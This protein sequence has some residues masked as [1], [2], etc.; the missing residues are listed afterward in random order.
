[1]NLLAKANFK[2]HG[3]IINVNYN[4]HSL[5]CPSPRKRVLEKNMF[6]S[7]FL[8]NLD[9]FH[10]GS[11]D[12]GFNIGAHNVNKIGDKYLKGALPV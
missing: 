7:N 3:Q 11:R 9:N 2:L 1:M 5:F 4:K 8:D 12:L 6:Y 10:S